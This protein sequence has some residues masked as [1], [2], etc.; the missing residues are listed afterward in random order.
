MPVASASALGGTEII[1]IVAVADE[2]DSTVWSRAGSLR[3][4]PAAL[5]TA[6][7]IA[8]CGDLP[9]AYLGR[10]MDALDLPLVF[11]PGNH[12]P[13]L[14]VYRLSRAG[15]ILRAGLPVRSPWPEAAINADGRV[16]DV[17]G[18]RVAGLGGCLRYGRGPNQYSQRQ[19]A[20]RA[21]ALRRRVRWR[22]FRDGNG[23]DLLLTHAPPRGV[24]D[25]DDLAHRGFGCYHGLIA[26]LQP[27]ALLHG[28]VY[29]SGPAAGSLRLGRTAVRNVIGLHLVDIAVA[30]HQSCLA[31]ALPATG[32][33]EPDHGGDHA[34]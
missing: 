4:H 25:S 8:A 14:S 17:A 19:Q 31:D 5:R 6:R 32:G 33:T 1:R 20:R 22:T 28:H 3:T 9:G 23:V 7:L 11:V 15:L 2:Q 30:S 24:G 12:D 29:P 18:L 34:R 10:L 21:G 26:A 16:V 27:A 13:D